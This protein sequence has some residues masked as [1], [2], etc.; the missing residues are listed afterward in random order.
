MDQIKNRTP[1]WGKLENRT[2]SP[3]DFYRYMSK[4]EQYSFIFEN[5][6]DG[7]FSYVGTG[8]HETLHIKEEK[9]MED[10]MEAIRNWMGH[11][12]GI[13]QYVS[14]LPVDFPEWTGGAVGFLSYDFV[15]TYER[16]PRKAKDDLQLPDVYL[17]KIEELFAF[18]EKNKDLYFIVHVGEDCRLKNQQQGEQRLKE[19]EEW[20]RSCKPVDP[21]LYARGD[22]KGPSSI[23]RSFQQREFETAVKKIQDY[24]RSG[25]VFQVN[26]SLRQSK[27]TLL[28]DQEI[29]DELRIMNPSPYM[30]L[31]HFPEFQLISASPELLLRVNKQEVSTR[32]IA[33]T[34]K[35]GKT[36][37]EDQ[38]LEAE[39]I[40]TEKEN[41]EHI[42]LVDL[43]RNDMGKVCEYGSVHVNE[44]MVVERYSHVMHLVSHVVGEL[45]KDKDVYDALVAL[46]PGGTITG[47][48]K[49]RTMEII[50]ELESVT[51]GPY[52]GSMIMLGFN[53]DAI[54]NIIIRTLILKNHLAYVQA[55][56]GIV[57]DSH[58][59]A[60]YYE[61][62]KKAEALWDAV[63]LGEAKLSIAEREE[64]LE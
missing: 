40:E 22:V 35:R 42:M 45:S 54:C 5:T 44:W 14:N 29:Y 10:P 17:M 20:Y 50:E 49:V 18:D 55:G 59:K 28:T 58:P 48:P 30:G 2:F 12:Q 1:M 23:E 39:L 52:T 61:S 3:W 8:P 34:R 64:S 13:D 46:F 16:L 37:Q 26:L 31:L 38:Q 51:R 53:G 47:A 24:I 27:E 6:G 9:P 33:G 19:M 56:A 4:R 60:E 43:E 25:D 62:L 21:E 32:P 63:A 7:R 57:I 36:R 41:A 15:R 11:N